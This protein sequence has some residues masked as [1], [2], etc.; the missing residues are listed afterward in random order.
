MI[1]ESIVGNLELLMVVGAVILAIVIFEMIEE[2]H[3]RKVAARRKRLQ[4]RALATA[5]CRM[6]LE[7][8]AA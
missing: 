5:K 1:K 4:E 7:D 3:K 2:A 8:L 6:E